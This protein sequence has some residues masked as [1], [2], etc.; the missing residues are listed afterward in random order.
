[1]LGSGSGGGTVKFLFPNHYKDKLL[2]V[3]LKLDD[4]CLV[5]WQTLE[6]G[7]GSWKTLEYDRYNY[8][9]NFLAIFIN[10]MGAR[11]LLN[12]QPRSART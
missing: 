2:P 10:A 3:F 4:G 11:L 12:K 6:S 7:S 8:K 1:V 5:T 9:Y